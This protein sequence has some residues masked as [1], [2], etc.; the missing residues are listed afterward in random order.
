MYNAL[1][2][3]CGNIGALY[4]KN[5]NNILTHL[6]GY[7]NKGIF[8]ISIY[9]SNKKLTLE[10]SSK[11]NCKIIEDINNLDYSYFDSIS[12]CT[13]T[14][15][16]YYFLKKSIESNVKSII[17]EKPISYSYKELSDI[18]ELQ[19]NSKILVNYIRRFQK[20]YIKLKK[21]INALKKEQNVKNISIFYQRGF[22]NNCS[23]AFDLIEFL[24]DEE[25]IL[26]N[27]TKSNVLYDT[28]DKDPTL[29]FQSLW[30]KSIFSVV[31]LTNI[32]YSIFEI[33]I[34]FES[35]RI[36]ITNSGNNVDIYN[37][38]S[39]SNKLS[40]EEDLSGKFILENYMVS[41][42][43]TAT[44]ILNGERLETNFLQSIS[45]NRKMLD[46]INL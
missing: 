13:P 5:N 3:G 43:D 7:K 21:Y 29:S 6:K 24:F 15:T 36:N 26:S 30:N 46:I 1:V 33:H 37:V 39:N 18:V 9:D 42:I 16:H 4:D 34:L 44:E 31:G 23:H 19:N 8:D 12:I 35:C 41:V 11:Y 40:F 20:Y 2:I 22:L 25:I 28:F 38:N 27:I 45:I 14:D 17:C 10:L 32:K